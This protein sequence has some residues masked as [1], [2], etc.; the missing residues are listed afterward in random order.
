MR[1]FTVGIATAIA[2]VAGLAVDPGLASGGRDTLWQVVTR[3]CVFGQRS[4]AISF[5]CQ[6]VDLN[7][8]YVVLATGRAHFLLVPTTRDV[9]LRG[10]RDLAAIAGVEFAAK[11][12]GIAVGLE[13]LE[14]DATFHDAKPIGRTR[15]AAI[16]VDGRAFLGLGNIEVAAE[17]LAFA[18]GLGGLTRR[19]QR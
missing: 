13:C 6:Y 15:P 11:G 3:L 8:G 17:D 14:N 19:R 5:P 9:D 10:E 12:P 7:K 2:L 4:A 16:E 18:H 1:R